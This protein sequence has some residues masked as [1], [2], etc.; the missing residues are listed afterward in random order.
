MSAH[1]LLSMTA[2]SI[3]HDDTSSLWDHPLT[4]IISPPVGNWIVHECMEH[5]KH[6][7]QNFED[8]APILEK[9]SL[10]PELHS[11][12]FEHVRVLCQND[13]GRFTAT[14]AKTNLA[15]LT[16]L[17]FY[18]ENRALHLPRKQEKIDKVKMCTY[19]YPYLCLYTYKWIYVVVSTMLLQIPWNH[20][21]F[22]VAWGFYT[23]GKGPSH[24]RRT[25]G[26]V[27]KRRWTSS[28]NCRKEWCGKLTYTYFTQIG[29]PILV[30]YSS[31]VKIVIFAATPWGK[32][33]KSDGNLDVLWIL[34]MIES[35]WD[36]C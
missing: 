11:F 12:S 15:K 3:L 21:V 24:Q 17:C 5:K 22:C 29:E 13:Q 7:T 10:F 33:S 35:S 9:H 28:K 16:K 20:Q 4:K 30:L 32:N 18:P 31:W 36:Q 8:W 19:K 1:W 27:N 26:L 25:L 34:G 2:I 6:V 23:C 14:Q